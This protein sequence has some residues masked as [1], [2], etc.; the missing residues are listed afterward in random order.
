MK[1]LQGTSLKQFVKVEAS[2]QFSEIVNALP[3]LPCDR[4]PSPV[5]GQATKP[6]QSNCTILPN[7]TSKSIISSIIFHL[8]AQLLFHC[9]HPGHDLG[10]HVRNVNRVAIHNLSSAK[11]SLDFSNLRFGVDFVEFRDAGLRK[12]RDI[13][14]VGRTPY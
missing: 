10:R 13:D 9:L 3:R 11:L 5:K 4:S 2:I 8:S 7:T 6:N 1:V 12:T 14:A